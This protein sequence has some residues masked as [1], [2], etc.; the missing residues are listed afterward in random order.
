M[1]KT[2]RIYL[3]PNAIDR[4]ERDS[5]PA[6]V[7]VQYHQRAADMLWRKWKTFALSRIPDRDNLLLRWLKDM[8]ELT[9]TVSSHTT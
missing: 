3:P 7:Y 4:S 6:R 5:M 2:G 8:R 9:G 1:F